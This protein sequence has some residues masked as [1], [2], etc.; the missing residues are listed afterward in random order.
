MFEIV[1]GL[2]ILLQRFHD[3]ASGANRLYAQ[4]QYTQAETAFG[5]AREIAAAFGGRSHPMALVRN[6][7]AA[8]HYRAGRESEARREWE[9]ALD[10]WTE[11]GP[12]GEQASAL[13]NLAELALGQ[14]RAAEGLTLAKQALSIQKRFDLDNV[15]TQITYARAL[16]LTGQERE[17]VSTLRKLLDSKRRSVPQGQSAMILAALAQANLALGNY[18]EAQAMAEEA[19]SQALSSGGQQSYVYA[20]AVF[21]RGRTRQMVGDR[22][23]AERD[24]TESLHIHEQ[25]LGMDHPRVVVLLADLAE[26]T[27]RRG[28]NLAALTHLNRAVAI[29]RA[30]SGVAHPDYPA[31]LLAVAQQH[32]TMGQKELAADLYRQ[33]LEA[34]QS[35]F[36]SPSPALAPY[37]NGYGAA[38]FDLG[39]LEEAERYVRSS[40]AV[41]ESQAGPLQP[42]LAE[43][44]RNLATICMRSGRLG[45]S[46]TFLE[47]SLAILQHLHGDAH[48]SLIGPLMEYAE[49]LERLG[50]SKRGRRMTAKARSIAATLPEQQHAVSIESL[51][52]FR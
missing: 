26:L 12:R 10:I 4:G 34:A 51:R 47:R 19:V 24:I 52:G 2:A 7:L 38:L 45:E 8:L 9:A 14:G 27:G 29:L 21:L 17:S 50:D 1:A 25:T 16:R 46:R 39:R 6:N 30:K 11:I 15:N 5:Q 13:S 31:L 28:G 41:H 48:E 36:A 44:C 23:G 22:T 18:T 3:L 43:S 49:V 40:V 42:G 35:L 37:F 32:R 33:A 20:W